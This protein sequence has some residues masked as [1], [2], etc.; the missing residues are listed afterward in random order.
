MTI[1]L[2][3]DAVCSGPGCQARLSNIY[4]TTSDKGIIGSNRA[5]RLAVEN[6]NWK[7]TNHG[8]GGHWLLC[9]NCTETEEPRPVEIFYSIACGNC[10][11][12]LDRVLQ[13]TDRKS[14][15]KQTRTLA[16]ERH[17]W[18]YGS[19]QPGHKFIDLCSD[20]KGITIDDGWNIDILVD[21]SKR[22]Q[23]VY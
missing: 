12:R 21:Y 13:A 22:N 10:S 19:K 11:A 2:H 17:G 8:T 7:A 3:F 20:C 9:P 18:A 16:R 4:T 6:H 5:K 1:Q 23:G 14:L 15:V